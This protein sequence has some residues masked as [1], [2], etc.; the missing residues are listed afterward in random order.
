MGGTST[1]QQ[2]TQQQSQTSPWAP[3]QGTLQDIIN[4][5]Q[6][7]AGNYQPSAAETSALNTM[8]QNYASAPNLAPQATSLA[9]DLS[10][11]GPDRTGILSGAY[12]NVASTLNP[13]L[14]ASYLDPT[15]TPGIAAALDTVRNDVANQVNG[16][17]AG[18]GRDLSGM[19]QQ[20]LARG[21]SQAEAPLL[22]NQYNQNV[23]AQQG[24]ANALM[25]GAGSTASGLSALDQQQFANRAQ[26]LGVGTSIPQLANS[27]ATGILNAA[28]MARS[29]PLQ[30]L[31][32]LEALIN[33]IAA[34]GGQS[35]GTS[36]T[37]S[38]STMSPVQ[39]FAMIAQGLGGLFTGAG[40]LKKGFG[41]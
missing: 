7:Q 19:N 12:S 18:A 32:A 34:L 22:L 25:S 17:F 6:G 37:T 40:N 14:N 21:I 30:N 29:L 16:Q 31:S 2:Q 9:N 27:N 11:G 3:T 36:N 35:T 4:G 15:Q 8:Q 28:S 26:G 39:Q 5:V 23:A 13:F 38:S 24:A 10:T 41:Q 20:A 33:P 1:Q